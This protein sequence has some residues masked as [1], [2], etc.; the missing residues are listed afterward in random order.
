MEHAVIHD[1]VYADLAG[2]LE[3]SKSDAVQLLWGMDGWRGYLLCP[4]VDN[5][6]NFIDF[7][8]YVTAHKVPYYDVPYVVVHY[9]T[10]S[11]PHA[12]H[13]SWLHHEKV[14]DGVALVACSCCGCG[15]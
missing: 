12:P 6:R 4:P 5:A 1:I 8:L 15:V 13:G 10:L 11:T 7:V 14:W 2:L 3:V 9:C